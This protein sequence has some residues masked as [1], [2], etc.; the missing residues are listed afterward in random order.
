MKR[1]KKN[2]EIFDDEILK[3]E[4]RVQ[5]YID[6]VNK[7]NELPGKWNMKS[8]RAGVIAIKIGMFPQYNEYFERHAVTCLWIPKCQVTQVK[9]KEKRRIQFNPSWCN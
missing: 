2:N 1:I 8:E 5:E 3:E 9:T 4:P 7:T 6:W